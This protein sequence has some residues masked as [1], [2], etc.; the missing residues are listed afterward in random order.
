MLHSDERRKPSTTHDW[1][2]N[3]PARYDAKRHEK[4][5]SSFHKQWDVY[6]NEIRRRGRQDLTDTYFLCSKFSWAQS[7]L[8]NVCVLRCLVRWV[9][10]EEEVDAIDSKQLQLFRKNGPL[11]YFGKIKD[12]F[13]PV[14][15]WIEIICIKT[16]KC[17]NLQAN[18]LKMKEKEIIKRDKI[19]YASGEGLNCVSSE[20]NTMKYGRST[21]WRKLNGMRT[22]TRQGK[23][24]K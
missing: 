1:K 9:F 11:C 12:K 10:W 19:N 5:T 3:T 18:S 16:S 15:F 4:N 2:D 13:K 17:R 20:V 7:Q 21:Y 14:Q 24:G 8:W 6:M 23:K 22:I